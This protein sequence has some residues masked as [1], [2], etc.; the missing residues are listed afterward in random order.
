M[1][2]WCQCC[3]QLGLGFWL[4]DI[5]RVMRA[6]SSSHPACVRCRDS[7]LFWAAVRSRSSAILTTNCTER[8]Q[9]LQSLVCTLLVWL[10]QT[11]KGL[12]VRM[13]SNYK[14]KLRYLS[15]GVGE[16]QR[17]LVYATKKSSHCKAVAAYSLR[18]TLQVV[19]SLSA[20]VQQRRQLIR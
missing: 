2:T 15:L 13:A 7:R 10:V 14:L 19:D 8:I 6:P 20:P 9:S 3:G 5:P 4:G 11:V 16:T 1:T 12:D 18:R 17:T